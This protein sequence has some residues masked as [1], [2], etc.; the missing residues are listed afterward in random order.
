ML[1]TIGVEIDARGH[2]HPV[3]KL[4]LPHKGK[5]RTLLTILSDVPTGDSRR[6]SQRVNRKPRHGA[7]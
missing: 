4:P 7:F 5:S 1:Q 6:V 3:E 2:I